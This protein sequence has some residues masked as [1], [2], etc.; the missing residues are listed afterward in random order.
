MTKS[1]RRI[2]PYGRF[3]LFALLASLLLVTAVTAQEPTLPVVLPNAETG[4]T[5][6]ADRCANCHGP[7]GQGDGE[8]VDRLE[9]PPANFT[10]PEFR[11]SRIPAEMFAAITNGNLASGMPPFGP[12]NQDNPISEVN[13]WDLVAAVYSLATPPEAITQGQIVYEE[14]CAACHGDTGLGDGPDADAQETPP[15]NLTELAYWYTRSNETVFAGI[16]NQGIPAHAYELADDALWAVVDYGRTF[17][18]R[19]ASSTTSTEPI[20]TATIGGVVTNA[21]TGQIITD[22]QVILRGFDASFQPTLT[23]TETV[24]ADGSYT[25]TLA[26][27]Q[28]DWVYLAS[29]EHEGIGFSSDAARLDSAN[30]SLSL[31]ITVFDPSTDPADITID[32]MHI[33]VNFAANSLQVNEFYIVSNLGNTVFV[34]ETGDPAAGTVRLS[35]PENAQNVTFFRAIGSMDSTIPADEVIQTAD[36][37]ADTFPLNPGSQGLNLIAS[38]DLPYEDGASLNRPMHYQVTNANVIMP[39]AGVTASGEGFQD[40]GV[41]T[42]GSGN[43]VTYNRAG[44][45][46]ETTLELSLNGRPEAVTTT[47]PGAIQ[48]RNNTQEL[49]IGGAS[50]LIV[51][52]VALFAVRTWRLRSDFD[53][54]EDD[55]LE[56]ERQQLLQ[57]IVA[58]DAAFEKGQ[59]SEA[60][61]TSQRAELKTALTEIWE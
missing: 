3:A 61:Y 60:E 40:L 10:D 28:P 33:L 1:P 35:L 36:G 59:I 32:Q 12:D 54:E 19:Y 43:F 13:R 2:A 16:A 46:P 5:L 8:L 17:S 18:Y 6:F 24:A 20:S 23:L 55:D 30:P 57:S 37:W 42:M 56:E 26:D 4:L 49:I 29:A 45:S 39:E 58:L 50:L 11:R 31:P 9:A 14:T 22:G 15:T 27:V 41:Q 48:P 7:A 53:E 25:F 51:A 44:V 52:G 21:T 34:G 38:Y 47:T